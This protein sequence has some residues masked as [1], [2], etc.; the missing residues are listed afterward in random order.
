MLMTILKEI[1]INNIME[2]KEWIMKMM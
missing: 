2:I 1:H